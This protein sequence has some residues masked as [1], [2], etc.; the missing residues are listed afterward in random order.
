VIARPDIPLAVGTILMAFTL[1]PNDF[2]L[3]RKVSFLRKY[4]DASC[5]SNNGTTMITCFELVQFFSRVA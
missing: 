3:L 1:T 4:N 5:A 2:D